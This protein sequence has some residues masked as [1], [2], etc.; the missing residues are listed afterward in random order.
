MDQ[1][2]TPSVTS[3]AAARPHLPALDGLR[4]IAILL[5]MAFHFTST[6]ATV[7]RGDAS[8]G[9]RVLYGVAG[10]GWIGVDL[11][12]VLSGFL[13]TGILLDAKGSASF[14]RNFY[15]RRVLRI[16]PLYY[17]FLA[18]L[19]II[20]PL[21]AG[22]RFDAPFLDQ[23]WYWLYLPNV[24]AAVSPSIHENLFHN[25]AGH[26]WSLAIEEQFYLI[27]PFCVIALARRRLAI[28]CGLMIAGALATRIALHLLGTSAYAVM[29]A[30]A[31]ALAMGALVALAVRSHSGTRWAR[32]LALPAAAAASL[33][34][35]AI[36]VRGSGLHIGDVWTQTAGLSALAALFAA[37]VF[38][39]SRADV[40]ALAS[41]LGW[42]PLCSIGKY[43][44]GIY[45]LHQPL[46]V[47]A[48]WRIDAAGG[49]PAV[50]GL[51]APAV[52]ALALAAG[53][54]AYAAAWLSWHVYESR[55]LRLKAR[56]A[57][58][59]AQ[60]IP[61]RRHGAAPGSAEII[62]TGETARK[63]A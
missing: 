54:A 39:A 12:F 11:F 35:T 62:P 44:Y 33:V 32:S 37:V 17:A 26:L 18:L 8:V 40:R 5:V 31:D 30:R 4:G 21:A 23:V 15:A 24:R 58:G 47:L 2:L 3:T 45:I 13:I 57:Y 1:A 7:A 16:F 22:A 52:L 42:R 36:A 56:F 38:G 61:R 49:M 25:A 43:S 60:H 50:L 34:V 19:L 59:A 10:A 14:L 27:W 9:D 48:A 6:G 28:L 29:P 55:F 51:Q 46:I 41:V 20:V 53:A 63:A